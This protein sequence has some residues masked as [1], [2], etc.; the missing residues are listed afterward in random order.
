MQ[1]YK[2]GLSAKQKDSAEHSAISTESTPSYLYNTYNQST[3][4]F[5]G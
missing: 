3:P 2:F 4:D 5:L 1:K